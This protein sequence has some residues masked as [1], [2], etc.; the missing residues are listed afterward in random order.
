MPKFLGILLISGYHQLPTQND[1]WSTA[2]DI[3]APIFGKIMSRERFRIIKDT[4][5]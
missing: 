5:I 4:Y 2:E 3:E 1:Y